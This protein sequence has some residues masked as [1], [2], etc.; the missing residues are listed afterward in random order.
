MKSFPVP[1]SRAHVCEILKLKDRIK[2]FNPH[3]EELTLEIYN[4]KLFQSIIF[5]YIA[6][7]FIKIKFFF[8]YDT[9]SMH[10]I[11]GELMHKL[12]LSIKI[13][14]QYSPY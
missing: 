2:I 12:F 6:T 3:R 4:Y 1:L 10:F 9:K 7:S 8:P 13:S 5:N 11:T 14:Q